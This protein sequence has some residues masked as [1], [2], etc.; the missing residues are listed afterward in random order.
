M[1]WDT[2]DDGEVGEVGDLGLRGE[3]AEPL[4]LTGEF[5]RNVEVEEYSVPSV[6]PGFE[7]CRGGRFNEERVS[8][9]SLAD[10]C[11]TSFISMGITAAVEVFFSFVLLQQLQPC[12]RMVFTTML[13]KRTIIAME[14]MMQATKA[15][16]A[17]GIGF[18][19]TLST[20]ATSIPLVTRRTTDK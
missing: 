6:P 7:K 10:P 3:S 17:R 14:N 2:T 15:T 19:L 9:F 16:A 5:R 18:T 12:G 1:D 20:N 11:S 8:R 4:C 13:M